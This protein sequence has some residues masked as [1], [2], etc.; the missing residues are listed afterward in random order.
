MKKVMCFLTIVA[1]LCCSF[2][3]KP[4]SQ[5]RTYTIYYNVDPVKEVETK[6]VILEYNSKNE[7]VDSHIVDSCNTCKKVITFTPNKMAEKIKIQSQMHIG[8]ISRCKWIEKVFYIPDNTNKLYIDN[9]T[10]CGSDEP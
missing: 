10:A 4:V 2:Q 5:N 3:V 1:L 9:Y 8:T 7:I 6:L